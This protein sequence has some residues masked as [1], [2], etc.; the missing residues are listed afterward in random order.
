MF[1]S[2]IFWLLFGLSAA[3]WLA[4][5]N[6]GSA[7]TSGQKAP[8]FIGENWLNSKPLTLAGLQGRV[9]LVE[10]WTYG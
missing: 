7:L 8:E 5:P 2:I 10:F 4:W 3:A 9:V 6:H 1:R